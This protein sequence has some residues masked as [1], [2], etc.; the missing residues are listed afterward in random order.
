V[1]AGLLS[2]MVGLAATQPGVDDWSPRYPREILYGRWADGDRSLNLRA[3]GTYTLREKSSVTT[4]RYEF[5]E[6]GLGLLD[7][8]GMPV[9]MPP[10]VMGLAV[11]EVDGEY[12]IVNNSLD[13]DAWDGWM[14][15]R[16]TPPA[17][18]R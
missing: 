3:D 10:D 2:M 17:K 1:L 8:S 18:V 6:W 7:A 12:R 16:R 15:Y 14:G 9:P 11:V 13:P 4:G 5:S